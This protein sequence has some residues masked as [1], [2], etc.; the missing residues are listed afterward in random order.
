MRRRGLAAGILALALLT[1]CAQSVDP[2]ERLGRKAAQEVRPHGH[3]GRPERSYRRWGLQA[4]LPRAPRPA[5][6]PAVRPAGPALPLVV[7]HVPTRDRVVFLTYDDGAARDPRFAAMVRELRLP[8]SVFGLGGTSGPG[9]GR[10]RPADAG[11]HGHRLGRATL[12]GLPYAGQRAEICGRHDRPRRRLF[13]PPH[14][15]YDG[16]TLRAAGDCGVTALVLWRA[17]V[18]AAGRLTYT[19]T[20]R[21]L[22]PGDIVSVA[23]D[24]GTGPPLTQRTSR[25]L[26]RVEERGLTVGRLEDYL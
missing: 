25:L 24:D 21:H 3:A 1:G 8:V 4:P 23:P 2:I 19:R 16:T 20:A 11:S 14:G 10:P 7:A 9:H 18:N 26:A 12:R 6:A 22:T 5:H 13:R 15:A 17:S